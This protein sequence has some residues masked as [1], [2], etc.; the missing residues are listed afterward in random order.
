MAGRRGIVSVPGAPIVREVDKNGNPVDEDSDPGQ[1][2]PH[3]ECPGNLDG[4]AALQNDA[5]VEQEYKALNTRRDNNVSSHA[6]AEL[7]ARA[8]SNFSNNLRHP[9]PNPPDVV[10]GP[11]NATYQQPQVMHTNGFVDIEKV[12]YSWARA[13]PTLF[14]LSYVFINGEWQWVILHDI[15]GWHRMRESKLDFGKWITYQLWQ[16]DGRPVAYPTFKLATHNHKMKKI[17]QAQRRHVIKT[18]RIDPN[19]TP[20]AIR[21]A[22]TGSTLDKAVQELLDLAHHHVANIPG[23]KQCM[24]AEYHKMVAINFCQS[25]VKGHCFNLFHTGSQAEFHEYALR[26]VLSSYISNLDIDTTLH[27]DMMTGDSKFAQAVQLHPQVVTHLF[28]AKKRVVA[29]HGH[30]TPLRPRGSRI[31][32]RARWWTWCHTLSSS[33]PHTERFCQSH[34]GGSV[35]IRRSATHLVFALSVFL[36]SFTLSRVSLRQ[37]LF[38]TTS[39]HFQMPSAT[40]LTN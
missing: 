8:V 13:F 4:P 34:P 19:I 31:Q 36:P 20:D 28:A 30:E 22:D 5:H 9:D 17:A 6:N 35:S 18:S 26:R 32:E 7:T 21:T 24:N 37:L 40:L 12:K 27:L 23:A 2:G 16:S 15:S 29:H 25:Y 39:C 1:P 38:S 3:H 11:D 10:L 14:P 33:W